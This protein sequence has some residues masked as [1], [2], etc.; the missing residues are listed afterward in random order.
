MSGLKTVVYGCFQFIL[1]KIVEDMVIDIYY[2]FEKSTKRKA[3]LAKFYSF[4]NVDN[5][6]YLSMSVPDG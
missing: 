6:R 3:S 4:C 5:I 2:W 1:L